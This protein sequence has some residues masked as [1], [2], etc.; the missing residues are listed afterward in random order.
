MREF[1]NREQGPVERRKRIVVASVRVFA[2]TPQPIR[3]T[4]PGNVPAL[5]TRFSRI[6]Q[7]QA[8]ILQPSLFDRRQVGRADVHDLRR[9]LSYP[10]GNPV[11]LQQLQRPLLLPTLL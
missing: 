2:L 4:E 7:Q 10:E 8:E 3:A 11:G 5:P 9:H 1:G 6:A